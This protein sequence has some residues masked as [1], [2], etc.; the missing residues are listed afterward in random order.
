MTIQEETI[1]TPLPTDELIERKE[2]FW[3]IKLPV[4]FKNFIKK[5]NGGIPNEQ[6]FTHKG[7]KYTIIRF[8]AIIKDIQSIDMEELGWYDIGVV[9]S[10][11]CER[12]SDNPD[13]LGMELIS[14]AKI[15]AEDY[16]CLDFRNKN[17]EPSICICFNDESGDFEPSTEKVAENFEDFIAMLRVDHH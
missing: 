14:I 15:F 9:S 4:S 16:L 13:L 1:I 6:L 11:I 8:L 2:S 17:I 3:R 7:D 10:P 5:S 12:L